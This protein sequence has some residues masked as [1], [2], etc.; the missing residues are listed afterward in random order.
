MD[1]RYSNYDVVTNQHLQSACKDTDAPEISL[2]EGDHIQV[3]QV[4]GLSFRKV[5]SCEPEGYKDPGV[6]ANDRVDGNV[7]AALIIV[8]AVDRTTIGTYVLEFSIHD[9]EGNVA[10]KTRTVDVVGYGCQDSAAYN[11]DSLAEWDAPGLCENFRFGC[12]DDNALN[13]DPLANTDGCVN[14]KQCTGTAVTVRAL[15]VAFPDTQFVY[16]GTSSWC[17]CESGFTGHHCSDDIDECSSYSCTHGQ[18]VNS[19]GGYMCMCDAG[20]IGIDC[21]DATDLSVIECESESFFNYE[22]YQCEPTS[23]LSSP[24]S[25]G[26]T[27]LVLTG[28]LFRCLCPVGFAGNVCSMIALGKLTSSGECNS[29]VARAGGCMDPIKFK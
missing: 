11:F 9:A 7:T 1:M 16:S 26:G 5:S 21:A 13:Y 17:E 20:H 14:G 15:A 3:S 29:C 23:C 25:N 22:T 27:C 8:G 4:C 2:T 12:R 19:Y 24:C 18:C 6:Y 10:S 28:G